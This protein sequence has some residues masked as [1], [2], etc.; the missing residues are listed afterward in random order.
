M[1]ETCEVPMDALMP[2]AHHPY[3]PSLEESAE[4]ILTY[5]WGVTLCPPELN[6]V[7]KPTLA[8]ILEYS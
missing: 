7:A 8:R 1:G 6:V 2:N 4:N 3:Q 5:W